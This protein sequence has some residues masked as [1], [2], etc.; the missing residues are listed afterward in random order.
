MTEDK[1][2]KLA[3]EH[4]V[5]NLDHT[6]VKFA[7]ALLKVDPHNLP[8]VYIAAYSHKQALSAGMTGGL[9]R[10][11]I[12]HVDSAE[13]LLGLEKGFFL[14]FHSSARNLKDYD[15]IVEQALIRDANTLHLKGNELV[16]LNPDEPVYVYAASA[17][18][19]RNVAEYAGLDR[20]RFRYVSKATELTG[21]YGAILWVHPTARTLSD[22]GMTMAI[23]ID[24]GL[25]ITFV[26]DR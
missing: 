25:R 22:Y 2:L 18:I 14:W 13:K 21:R 19:A 26:T 15:R 8:I 17:I 9:R 23:A 12:K 6:L 20:Q 16:S 4:G 7:K 1:I 10:Q 24:R 11:Q 5:L 3:N